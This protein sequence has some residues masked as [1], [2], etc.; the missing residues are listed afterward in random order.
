MITKESFKALSAADKFDVLMNC[1]EAY[2]RELLTSMG[3]E[4]SQIRD[5]AQKYI[6]DYNQAH[7]GQ[8][9]SSTEAN[10]A[11]TH[12]GS[13]GSLSASRSSSAARA[14]PATSSSSAS[15]SSTTF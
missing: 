10:Y 13:V 9:Q 1:D 3:S 2:L 15:I 4:R 11:A 14:G 8:A 7:A 5:L 6:D 12:A